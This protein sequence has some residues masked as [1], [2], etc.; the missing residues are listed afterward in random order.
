MSNTEVFFTN[1][2]KVSYDLSSEQ[3]SELTGSLLERL[4]LENLPEGSKFVC[5]EL[6]QN[7]DF[8]NLSRYVEER[9][10][11]EEFGNNKDEMLTEYGPYESASRFWL[12]CDITSHQP[13]GALRVIENSDSGLKT[14]NDIHSMLG[15]SPDDVRYIENLDFKKT[16]DVGTVAVLPE[17][18]GIEYSF[19]PSLMLYR[20]LY[21]RG[22][23]SGIDHFVSIIDAKA[24]SNLELLGT[25][26]RPI[27]GL[28]SFSYL[29]SAESTALV[30][31]VDSLAYGV[32]S[33]IA[34]VS[35][36]NDDIS[37]LIHNSC[38]ALY[39]GVGTDE[40]RMTTVN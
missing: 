12:V 27:L 10:F 26:F 35:T 2:S 15:V 1:D 20:S 33:R 37:K 30:S 36:Y 5:T 19:L 4:P 28:D 11:V 14:I 24:A 38:R 7:S 21:A 22:V 18:R 8:S 25:T 16:W 32:Q 23:E 17:Y 34:E 9:V 3:V 31:R 29:G 13:I 6:S 40:Y 39:D